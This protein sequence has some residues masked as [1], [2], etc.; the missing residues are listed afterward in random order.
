[1]TLKQ[2]SVTLCVV[3]GLLISAGWGIDI[4]YGFNAELGE[5]LLGAGITLLVGGFTGLL[6]DLRRRFHDRQPSH[7]ERSA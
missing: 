3:S 5:Y 6:V 1:M 2:I 7:S 4:F